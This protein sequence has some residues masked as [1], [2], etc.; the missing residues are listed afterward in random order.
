MAAL[1]LLCNLAGINLSKLSKEE[2]L[3]FEAELFWR[4]CEELKEAFREQHKD[5]FCLMKFSI[6]KENSMLENNFV[7]LIIK[8]ILST[9]EYNLQGFAFYANTHE[10]IVQEVIDGRNKNPSAMLLRRSIDLHRLVRR[11]LYQSII[12]KITTECLVMA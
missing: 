6:E 3:M 2:A 12:K 7:S 9:E 8:D 4:I 10:D 11:D 1:E 5:Y